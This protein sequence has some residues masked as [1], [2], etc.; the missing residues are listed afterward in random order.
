MQEALNNM[1]NDIGA[2]I[3]DMALY[4]SGLMVVKVKEIHMMYNKY[5]P[6]RAGKYFNLPKWISLKKACI[7]IKNKDAK[8]FKYAI[9][10]GYHKIYEKSHSDNFYHYKKIEDC[11]NFDGVTFPANNNDIDKFEEL[12]HNVSVNV[13]EV[14][15]EQ[16]QIVIGRKLKNKDAKCH[17]DLLRIDEDDISH[18]VYVKDCSRLLNSQKKQI[19]Q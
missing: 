6:T 2:R 13:F 17:I 4:Q 11:L 16:E 19:S 7:N 10:C 18:Y 14:D 15:D 5:N 8:C 3:L 9:Q 12:H 1:R